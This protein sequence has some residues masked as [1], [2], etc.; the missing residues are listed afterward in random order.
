MGLTNDNI[1]PCPSHATSLHYEAIISPN[2]DPTF[3]TWDHLSGCPRQSPP[4]P[5][6]TTR[7]PK[8]T[9]RKHT[10][11]PRTWRAPLPNVATSTSSHLH[12]SPRAF[13]PPR[14]STHSAGPTP[15]ISPLYYNNQNK[16]REPMK[17]NLPFFVRWLCVNHKEPTR[18]HL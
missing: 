13:P 11:S 18:R 12:V 5:T 10:S 9:T 16:V 6:T 3:A 14:V 4:S 1:G 17:S 7:F 15:A 8:A 2:V